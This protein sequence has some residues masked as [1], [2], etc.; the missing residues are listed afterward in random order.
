M[1]CAVP[2][3]CS[4]ERKETRPYMQYK[5][6]RVLRHTQECPC[7]DRLG[8]SVLVLSCGNITPISVLCPGATPTWQG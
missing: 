5:S 2:T 6:A 3:G 1:C 8:D 7:S 4:R